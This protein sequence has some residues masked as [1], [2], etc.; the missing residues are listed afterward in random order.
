MSTMPSLIGENEM[1]KA[2]ILRLTAQRDA[3]LAAAK[4]ALHLTTGGY[5]GLLSR[6]DADKEVELKLRQAIQEAENV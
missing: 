3:L 1:R 6:K 5:V 2:A 4:A